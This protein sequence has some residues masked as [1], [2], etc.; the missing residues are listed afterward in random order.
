M[1]NLVRKNTSMVTYRAD[2]EETQNNLDI[3]KALLGDT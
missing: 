3:A 1:V 2:S